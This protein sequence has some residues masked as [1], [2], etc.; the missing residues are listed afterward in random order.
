MLVQPERAGTASYLHMN[1][2]EWIAIISNFVV[3]SALISYGFALF[4]EYHASGRWAKNATGLLAGIGLLALAVAMLLTPRNVM[5]LL[6]VAQ[7]G[8]SRFFLVVSSGLLLAAI[9]AFGIINYTKPLRLWHERRIGRALRRR[10]PR[11]P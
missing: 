3:I 4:A 5:V 10:L 8:A 11:V 2:K 9:A 6:E 1:L 7:T